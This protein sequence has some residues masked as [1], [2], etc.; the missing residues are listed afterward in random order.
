MKFAIPYTIAI[1]LLSGCTSILGEHITDKDMAAIAADVP[2]VDNAT[3]DKAATEAD[4]GQC[5]AL[6]TLAATCEITRD[7]SRFLAGVK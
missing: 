3:Q 5:P 2:A 6:T 7:Q 1:L 4:S